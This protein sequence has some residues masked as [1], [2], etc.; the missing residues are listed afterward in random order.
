MQL[1]TL[2][3]DLGLRDNY[4]A[5]VKASILKNIADSTV[6]DISHEI[7][8]FNVMQAAYVFGNA[9][10]HFPENTIHLVGV[11][12]HTEAKRLLYIEINKQKIVCPDNG[13]FTLLPN[14]FDAK[15]YSLREKDF[16][17]GLFFLK[18]SMVKAAAHLQKE[19][20]LATA[21]EDYAQLMSFQPTAT[22]DSIVGR[23]LH[24]DSF[25]N[26]VT[27]ITQHFFDLVR[28]GRKFT[29]HLPGSQIQKIV[30]DYSE[31]PETKALALFNSFGYLEIAINRARASQLLFP[32]NSQAN[33]DFNI[34]VQFEG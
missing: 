9:Y 2:T 16:P 1:I 27:N 15:V 26:V 28:K 32:K 31:V 33:V 11:K 20:T 7:E 23:C 24:I 22:S 5:L 19:K 8:K 29:I 21:C 25:G 34:T 17:L 4:V 13:F 14:I 30:S 12:S 6:I 10:S 3:S 18:D